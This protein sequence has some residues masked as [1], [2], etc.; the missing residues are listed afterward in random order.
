MNGEFRPEAQA[1]FLSWRLTSC[2]MRPFWDGLTFGAA[3]PCRFPGSTAVG[4]T[5]IGKPALGK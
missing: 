5:P 3:L 2:R 1:G 4:P